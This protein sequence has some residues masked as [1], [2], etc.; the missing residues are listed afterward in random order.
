MAVS[1]LEI[2][3]ERVGHGPPL[4]L[5]HGAPGDS[6]LWRPQLDELADEFT[7]V[8]WDAPGGGRSADP[9]ESYLLPDFADCLAGFI[10]ALGL[11]QP[12]VLGLSFGG[13]LALQL[14]GRHPRL[15]RSLV[16]A[17]AYAGWAGSLPAEVVKQRLRSALR[18]SEREPRQAALEFSQ[19]LFDESVGPD[20]VEEV[21]GILADFHPAGWR[22]MARALADA[23]LRDVLPSIDVPTLLLY[24]DAD[25]RAPLTVATA[26]EA[27]IPGATLSVLPGIGHMSNLEAPDLFNTEVRSFLRSVEP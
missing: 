16:L 26:L 13:G 27:D 6:R 22:T 3:F 15:P 1:G 17:G 23:D 4:V 8:A 5:L 21:V 18:D 24:G 14:V 20:L 11:G 9:P 7:V 2:A 10:A 25:R 19:S 12:H